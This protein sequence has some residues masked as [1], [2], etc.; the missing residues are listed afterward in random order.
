[1]KKALLIVGAVVLVA[2]A[3]VVGSRFVGRSGPKVTEPF[4]FDY[5]LDATNAKFFTEGDDM[6]TLLA[7][8][9]FYVGAQPLPGQRTEEF[10]EARERK[11]EQIIAD[12]DKLA[13]NAIALK[14]DVEKL[15][16]ALCDYLTIVR[17][18]EPNSGSYVVGAGKEILR[19]CT[20]EEVVEAEYKSIDTSSTDAFTRTF[21]QYTKCTKAVR[22]AALY[23][24]DIENMGAFAAL[25]LNSL[26]GSKNAKI[27]EA[28]K[29]LDDA[30][31]A[32]DGMSGRISDVL[33][34][35]R[36]VDYGFR[37]LA[38]GDHYFARTAVKF[39]RESMPQLKAAAA[40]M[41]PN[42]Y[43]DAEAVAVTRGYLDKFD[44]LSADLLKHLDSVPESDLVPLEASAP[45]PS[46][47]A[48]AANVPSDYAKAF[49]SVAQPTKDTG[50]KKPGWLATGWSGL[51]KVVHGTQSVIGAGVDVLGTSV[52]NI[53][54]VGAGIYYG[55]TS[56]EIWED[57][58]ANSNQIVKNWKANKSGSDTMRTANQYMNNVD[59]GAEWLGEKAVEKTLGKGWTSWLTGKVTRGVSG[60]FTGLGK[61][62]TLVGNRQATTSDYVIG[63]V[64]IGCSFIGG[65]KVIM[66]GSQ[67]PGFMKGLAQGTWMSGKRMM[68]AVGRFV[69]NLEKTELE[70]GI[71]QALKLGME[72]AG[73][74]ARVAINKA[75][76][77]AIEASNKA[78]RAELGK[79]IE[80]AAKAGTA[81]FTGT[82]RQSMTD[83]V[84]TKFANNIKG[85]AAA[86]A[87]AAGEN[88]TEFLN[89]VVGQ[90]AEDALKELVDQ[91]MAEAPLAS[92]LSGVWTGTTVFT[93]VG[94]PAVP[95]AKQ[96]KEGCDIA[97]AIKALEGKPLT[98]KMKIVGSRTGSGSMTLQLS[99]GKQAGSPANASYTYNEGAITINQGMEGSHLT[100]RGNATRMTQGYSM[101][102]TAAGS[103]GGGESVIR[104]SGTFK[105]TKP[106]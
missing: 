8:S 74:N 28:N 6:A 67:V 100:L 64:E 12:S 59:D 10:D 33:S 60:I 18:N 104:L 88:P 47:V 84:K 16:K 105:V 37:Q 93:S 4:T 94:L 75:M 35:M 7:S 42:Q 21:M 46:G 52:K 92:E 55:N 89:N 17:N 90:W 32:L 81:N 2:V 3:I 96:S 71:K 15:R 101:S 86:L 43:M 24:Q 20:L 45:V 29:K 9:P 23:L 97:G 85:L 69:E 48:F 99:H 25:G 73:F 106:H 58:Q 51:K 40:N 5:K 50:E 82:L 83:F 53:T 19:I 13:E 79:L 1:M 68:N 102:G 22:L 38:T 95:P 56:K 39:M 54:R 41:K 78:L 27:V 62:M 61:G 70:A 98:T 26:S 87:K 103:I 49:A 34:G 14:P 44:R 72:T 63:T 30:M 57:M 31:G 80:A 11:V 66:K 76:I 65:S 36:K 77:E 91:V